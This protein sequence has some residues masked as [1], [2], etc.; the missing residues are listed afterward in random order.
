MLVPFHPLGSKAPFYFIHGIA[1]VMPL[2]RFLAQSLGPDQPIYAINANNIDQRE[3]TVK[4][5]ANTYVEEILNTKPRGSIFIGGMCVGGLAALEVARELEKR[6][7]KV[8]PVIIA[9]PPAVPQGLVPHNQTVDPQNPLVAAQLNEQVRG[10][11]LEFSSL[12]YN[13]MP[14]RHD[15]EQ[16]VRLATSVGVKALVAFCRYVPEVFTGAAVP[17]LS[18]RRAAKFFHPQMPWAKILPQKC[19]AFVLPY[20]HTDLFQTGRHD[21]ARVLQFVLGEGVTFRSAVDTVVA[22]QRGKEFIHELD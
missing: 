6:G 17:I 7:Q 12:P 3:I 20:D 4:D 5:M 18:S 8:G 22:P 19:A 9:D 13:E 14:F 21:F 10:Q 15:D 16:Q 1:G 2:G 11:L